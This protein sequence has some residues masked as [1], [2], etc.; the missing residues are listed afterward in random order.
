MAPECRAAPLACQGIGLY[1][2]QAQTGQLL[3]TAMLTLASACKNY[4]WSLLLLT[5]S[6][7]SKAPYLSCRHWFPHTITEEHCSNSVFPVAFLL[8]YNIPSSFTCSSF[9]HK[10][11]FRFPEN[12]RAFAQLSL[13]TGGQRTGCPIP[14]YTLLRCA[15]WPWVTHN[16]ETVEY[17]LTSY[18]LT[19]SFGKLL[20]NPQA[21]LPLAFS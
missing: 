8:E 21:L 15:L 14:A 2:K 13:Q 18:L 16:R 19:R 1:T 7:W 9:K 10:A 17:L 12:S 3:F 11:S 6:T 5:S 20:A 4:T